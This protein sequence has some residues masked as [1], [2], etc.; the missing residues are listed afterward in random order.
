MVSH[1][2]MIVACM[3]VLCFCVK[4]LR[5]LLWLVHNH[6]QNL[7][8]N[9]RKHTHC[10]DWHFFTQVLICSVYWNSVL[11][12][13]YNS[14]YLPPT[15]PAR[16]CMCPALNLRQC[17]MQN[18]GEINE[19]TN[20]IEDEALKHEHSRLRFPSSLTSSPPTLPCQKLLTPGCF[21]QF[22]HSQSLF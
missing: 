21:P 11:T 12:D 5:G 2:L 3:R 19:R 10:L 16:R 13:V 9:T 8:Q 4:V 17:C 1:N 6:F 18:N 15:S 20:V 14:I 7:G 22:C